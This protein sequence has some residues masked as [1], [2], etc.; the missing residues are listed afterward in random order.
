MH[1]D[2]GYVYLSQKPADMAK[3]TAEWN[4]VVAIDP[5]SDMAKTV[6]SHLKKG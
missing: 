2:L 1:Y 6:A 4:K 3:M 5:N